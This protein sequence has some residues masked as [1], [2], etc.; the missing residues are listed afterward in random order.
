MKQ[1]IEVAIYCLK[2]NVTVEQFLQVADENLAEFQKLDGFLRREMAGSEDGQWL[3][4]VYYDSREAAEAAEP[5]LSAAPS[6]QTIM[7][8][9][10]MNNGHW[11]HAT[12][13]R[14]Y[15]KLTQH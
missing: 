7:G 4:M 5:V 6:I 3:D 1:Y 12:P 14:H 10:D 9:L 13:I 2:P 11:F 8:M 15:S